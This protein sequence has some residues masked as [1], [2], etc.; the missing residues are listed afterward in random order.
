ME[1]FERFRTIIRSERDSMFRWMSHSVDLVTCFMVPEEDD[2]DVLGHD[3]SI[4]AG[5]ESLRN[6]VDGNVSIPTQ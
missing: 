4:H 2:R 3:G 5:M 1:E 6:V